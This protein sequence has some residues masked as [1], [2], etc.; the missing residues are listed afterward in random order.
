MCEEYREQINISKAR[1]GQI[2][3]LEA[4]NEQFTGFSSIWFQ[5]GPPNYTS[6]NKWYLELA[7]S[8]KMGSD[9]FSCLLFNQIKIFFEGEEVWFYNKSSF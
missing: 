1:Y 3:A 5:M 9:A 2:C 7:N 6:L 8:N 4:K